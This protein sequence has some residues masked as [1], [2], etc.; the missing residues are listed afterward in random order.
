MTTRHEICK[1]WASATPW[2]KRIPSTMSPTMAQR[3]LRAG[4][5]TYH[6][7]FTFQSHSPDLLQ[8]NL[9]ISHQIESSIEGSIKLT[10]VVTI[11]NS[12]SCWGWQFNLLC[13]FRCCV[14]IPAVKKF[15]NAC[16]QCF[17][18]I[19]LVLESKLGFISSGRWWYWRTFSYLI[20]C[21]FS[22]VTQLMF[23]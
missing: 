9:I 13:F 23:S 4:M 2:R 5:K 16:P 6:N 22:R 12:W 15:T 18:V 1:Q 21:F 17:L 7:H 10:S 20:W 3:S 8:F 19:T 14:N 11:K